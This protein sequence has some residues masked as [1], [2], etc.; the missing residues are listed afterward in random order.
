[1]TQVA[2]HVDRTYTEP[3]SM[4]GSRFIQKIELIQGVAE[5]IADQTPT[6]PGHA[7]FCGA[8][9]GTCGE[10]RPMVP[11]R[12]GRVGKGRGARSGVAG[13]H[14]GVSRGARPGAAVECGYWGSAPRGSRRLSATR[15]VADH[16]F[17]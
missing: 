11:R 9:L 10:T 5:A 15:A 13:G 4:P 6:M 17:G 12:A 1:M 3:P 2:L 14:Y 16:S 7:A 8:A